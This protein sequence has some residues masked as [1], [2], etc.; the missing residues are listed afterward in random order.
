MARGILACVL[1]AIATLLLLTAT[2]SAV[3]PESEIDAL[4]ADANTA[5][6]EGRMD[7][8]LEDL[9]RALGVA[10]RLQDE[11]RLA[12]VTGSLGSIYLAVGNLDLARQWLV[13]GLA[14]AHKAGLRG[15]QASGQNNLG[16]LLAS[17]GQTSAAL[18]AFDQAYRLARGTSQPET[19]ASAAINAAR[20]HAEEGDPTAA[21]TWLSSAKAALAEQAETRQKAM[22]ML[23]LGRQY[24][25]LGA[26]DEAVA[27][28]ADARQSADAVGDQ[29]FQSYSLGY[30]GEIYEGLGWLSDAIEL[31]RRALFVAQTSDE[32]SVLY[33]WQWQLGRIL[34][35]QGKTD[36]AIEAY[37]DAL[38]TLGA[39]RADLINITAQSGRPAFRETFEP[40]SLELADLLLRRAA[41]TPDRAA[42]QSDLRRARATVEQFRAA[43]LEDYFK[44]ECVAELQARIQP[45]DRLAGRTAAIYPIILP[46]RTV[47]LLTLPEGLAQVSIPVP[48]EE[49]TSKVHALRRLLEKRTTRQYLPLAQSL[50]DMLLRP[51]DPRLRAADIETV[52]FVPDGPLRTIPLAA[53]NDGEGFVI[54]RYA[55]ATVPGLNL[56]D[57]R[58]VGE[59]P[60]TPLITGI[61]EAVQG[62]SALPFVARELDTIA[63]LYGGTVLQDDQFVVP[64]VE[65]SLARTPYSV[66]HIASHAKF[67][68]DPKD[69]FLL[70]YDGQLDMD[71]LEKLIKLSRFQEEPV[72]LLTL[73]ACR[74]AAG[75]DRASLG[76]AGL[77][78]KAGARSAL[79]TLWFINDESSSLLVSEFYRHLKATP[80]PTKAE[81]LQRAQQVTK[82][83]P[84]YRHPAHWAPFLMIGNWL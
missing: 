71:G 37:H 2:A 31:T 29:V 16:N 24:A 63:K 53:L 80:T 83:D 82:S 79:A 68:G 47:M 56:L 20:L 61:T 73:S 70:T 26:L 23:A 8:A 54:D 7:V 32:P 25:A 64:E 62:F 48:A 27:A 36:E 67:A 74:T 4:L 17:E 66:V 30:T 75:D 41:A 44:D 21:E 52:V 58:P 50:Y 14:L 35:A 76:L 3:E 59:V 60:V 72:E 13:N 10:E 19:A 12:A 22:Q 78:I 18:A 38:Q 6:Q 39:F 11:A 9:R 45:I 1:P 28:Y 81:A 5:Q 65:Q 55:I 84:R 43:E 33:L 15:L 40:V 57:P 51:I 77:A 49:L 69:S 46:E 34:A 42:K